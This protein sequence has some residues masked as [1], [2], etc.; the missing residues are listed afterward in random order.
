[1][2]PPGWM[3]SSKLIPRRRLPAQG[4]AFADRVVQVDPALTVV[5]AAVETVDVKV[6]V[7]V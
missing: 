6:T 4:C 1:M 3:K 2:I 5:E 7:K